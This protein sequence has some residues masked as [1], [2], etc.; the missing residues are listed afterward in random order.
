M[1]NPDKLDRSGPKKAAHQR[2][3]QSDS[4]EPSN[5]TSA[6]SSD[7]LGSNSGESSE[8][9]ENTTDSPDTS[10]KTN[11]PDGSNNTNQSEDPEGTTDEPEND[12]PNSEGED[13]SDGPSRTFADLVDDED[14]SDDDPEE[15]PDDTPVDQP[16]EPRTAF[17]RMIAEGFEEEQKAGQKKMKRHL[18]EQQQQQQTA[19]RRPPTILDRLL[20]PL[21]QDTDDKMNQT[22]TDFMDAS[23]AE[24]QQRIEEYKNGGPPQRVE[25][26]YNNM[27]Q[28]ADRLYDRKEEFAGRDLTDADT[29][30]LEND[31]RQFQQTVENF[32]KAMSQT[33]A[34]I[35]PSEPI[36]RIAEIEETFEDLFSGALEKDT[37][38]DPLIDL[39]VSE[40]IEDLKQF[41]RDVF[42]TETADPKQQ[43]AAKPN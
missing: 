24:I 34:P 18:D 28:Q 13:E 19:P 3:N 10:G 1:V 42:S 5:S 21:S 17:G 37:D 16:V 33:D 30:V 15:E 31:F 38:E 27:V 2:Y 11:K 25:T 40:M 35:D 26:A 12:T 20:A 23:A 9:A 4:S 39:D 6:E 41:I 8:P 36:D 7:P 32:S 14:D 43:T 22:S 29:T